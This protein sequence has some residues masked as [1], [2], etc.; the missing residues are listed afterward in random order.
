M[1]CIL[2][3]FQVL[4]A[5][6]SWWNYF[7]KAV[8]N[9]FVDFKPFSVISRL[10]STK[11]VWKWKKNYSNISFKSQKY[12]GERESRKTKTTFFQL[13]PSDVATWVVIKSST[14]LLS[15]LFIYWSIW[16]WGIWYNCRC[17]IVPKC[18]W[19]LQKN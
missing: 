13:S 2:T 9:L 14:K 3:N 12:L 7:F 16:Y 18:T 8:F 4:E 11:N 10:K 19:G 15:N 1:F 6:E 5:P 17:Y